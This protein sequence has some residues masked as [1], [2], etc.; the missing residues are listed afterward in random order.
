[1]LVKRRFLCQAKRNMHSSS[2]PLELVLNTILLVINVILMFVGITCTAVIAVLKYNSV[3]DLS[4]L[5]NYKYLKQLIEVILV[6]DFSFISIGIFFFIAI[7]GTIGLMGTIRGR[8]GKR[9]FLVYLTLFI[10]LF[11]SHS[12]CFNLSGFKSDEVKSYLKEQITSVVN[13]LEQ[14]S[15]NKYSNQSCVL[16][17]T[18]STF[19]QCCDFNKK[20]ELL[21]QKCCDSNT[22]GKC[23][24]GLIDWKRTNS[25]A[26]L[27]VSHSLILAE[28]LIVLIVT[29]MMGSVNYEYRDFKRRKST[30]GNRLSR[31]SSV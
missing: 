19:I 21:S 8:D 13:R 15:K 28:F 12:L 7:L 20:D 25:N 23:F 27:A 1:M 5:N 2:S 16:M 10:V 24:E 4:K 26:I 30:I 29:F 11:I 18:M 9:Y 31:Y 14:P 17:K 6:N 3:S 22:S